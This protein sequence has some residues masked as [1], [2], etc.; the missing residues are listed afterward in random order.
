MMTFAF[1]SD[2]NTDATRD[3]SAP[4][5]IALLDMRT[6]VYSRFGAEIL[7]AEAQGSQRK[8]QS[9][10]LLCA[11]GVSAVNSAPQ[12][13]MRRGQT[14]CPPAFSGRW[15]I[16]GHIPGRSALIY[17]MITLSHSV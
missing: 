7:T 2:D 3:H 8:A 13:R 10:V 5:A 1:Q 12:L 17:V 6:G 16:V 9:F 15:P 11:L 14:P 4:A